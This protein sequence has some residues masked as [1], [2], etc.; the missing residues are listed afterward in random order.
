MGRTYLTRA[1]MAIL[2][3]KDRRGSSLQALK[4]HMKLSPDKVC[5]LK[6]ALEKG[7]RTGVL[8]K[9]GLGK[10]TRACCSLQPTFTHRLPALKR[11]NNTLL[12][13]H[14]SLSA[15]AICAGQPPTRPTRCAN[16]PNFSSLFVV[17]AGVK[18]K[19]KAVASKKKAATKVRVRSVWWCVSVSVLVLIAPFNDS[20]STLLHSPALTNGR[21]AETGPQDVP[22]Q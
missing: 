19:I 21:E 16:R 15:A 7:V 13:L 12:K 8:V 1:L 10:H 18:Y 20:T 22:P 3:L 4:N 2:A 11:H 5:F 6:Q 14:T 17:K 9:V